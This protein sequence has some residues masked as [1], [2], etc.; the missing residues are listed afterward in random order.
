[1]SDS[2]THQREPWARRK[3]RAIWDTMEDDKSHREKRLLTAVRAIGWDVRPGMLR[4]GARHSRILV[5]VHV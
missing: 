3:R 2:A 4:C 5:Q 1:M